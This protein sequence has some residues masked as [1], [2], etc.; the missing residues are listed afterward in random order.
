MSLTI[1]LPQDQETALKAKAQARGVSAEMYVQQV[2]ELDLN[3][4][5]TRRH[6]SEMIRGNMS[7]IPAE[8]LAALPSDGSSQVDHYVYGLPKREP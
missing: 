2:L 8:A 6:I 3:V 4:G 5:G 1:E 7:D